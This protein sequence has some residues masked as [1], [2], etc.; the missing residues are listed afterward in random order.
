MWRV[1]NMH[2]IY[3]IELEDEKEG[4][5]NNKNEPIL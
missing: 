1:N 5:N 4:I 3:R 2:N